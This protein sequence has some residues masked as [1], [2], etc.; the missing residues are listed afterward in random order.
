MV[1]SGST[2]AAGAGAAFS[3]VPEQAASRAASPKVPIERMKQGRNLSVAGVLP[4]AL[5]II[6]VLTALGL[7]LAL[8]CNVVSSL[9]VP[10][11]IVTRLVGLAVVKRDGTEIMRLASL[12]RALVAWL[13]AI[14]WLMF[15]SVSPR[16]E[17]WIP[18][19]PSHVPTAVLLGILLVG[20]GWA[21]VKPTRGLHD[22]LLGTWIVPR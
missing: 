11:G 10:G 18:A 4:L 21:I 2:D 1:H 7:L 15:L 16:I 14:L 20:A 6:E 12:A 19:P 3:A 5:I 22:R 17:G 8:T 9:I 13:P